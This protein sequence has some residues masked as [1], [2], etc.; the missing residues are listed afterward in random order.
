VF[1]QPHTVIAW[2]RKRFREHWTRL[3]RHGKP[4]RP[5]VAKEV[6]SLIH[7]MSLTNPTWGM[8]RIVGELRKLGIHVAKSTV[9]KYRVRSRKPAVAD[10]ESVPEEP[11][12][13]PGVA[14]L[15]RCPHDDA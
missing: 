11:C 4:R 13:R 1:V 10:L 7:S 5:A 8:P 2:Q 9:E 6:Q 14:R 3:S 15:F 12:Q